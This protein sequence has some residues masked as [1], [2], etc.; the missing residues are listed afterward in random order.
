MPFTVEQFFEVFGQ[1]N[2][3]LWPVQ[4]LLYAPAAGA[5]AAIW[6]RRESSSGRVVAASLAVL[7]LWM[8]AVYHLGFF[9]TINPAADLFAALSVAGAGL[10]FWHGVVRNRL[11]FAW[12]SGARGWAAVLVLAYALLLYPALGVLAGHSYWD[13]PTFGTPCPTTIFTFGVLLLAVRPCP[14]A[15]WVAPVV[16]ALVGTFAAF[17]LGVPQDYGLLVAGGIAV[18]YHGRG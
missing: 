10:F 15:V 1:Y 13:S 18:A 3:T 16:W 6:R 9:R 2:R 8:G 7:W 11:N 14:R 5:L 4:L 17:S 12:P